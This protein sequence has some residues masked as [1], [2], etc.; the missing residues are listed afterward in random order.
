MLTANTSMIPPRTLYSPTCRV[1]SESSY[2]I[3]CKRFSNLFLFILSP[4][5]T[6]ISRFSLLFTC[7]VASLF[8]SSQKNNPPSFFAICFS[9]LLTST[10]RPLFSSFGYNCT[11]RDGS[12]YTQPPASARLEILLYN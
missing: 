11:L 9:N 10:K 3:S 8:I 12:I 7:I 1:A 5:S 6:F 4:A 2:S